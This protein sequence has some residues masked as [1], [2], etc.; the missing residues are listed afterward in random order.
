MGLGR[1]WLSELSACNGKFFC[2]NNSQFIIFNYYK[3]YELNE[4]W[5]SLQSRKIFDPTTFEVSDY[6]SWRRIR[7]KNSFQRVPPLVLCI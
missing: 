4:I 1:R 3:K 7:F 2:L 6:Q 5:N